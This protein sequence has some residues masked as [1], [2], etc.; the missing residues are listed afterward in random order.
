V[1]TSRPHS[2]EAENVSEKSN[3][4]EPARGAADVEFLF[5]EGDGLV[6]IIIGLNLLH[7]AMDPAPEERREVVILDS[8]G[9]E[10]EW[11]S[12]FDDTFMINDVTRH[13]EGKRFWVGVNNI[14]WFNRTYNNG[15]VTYP[16][17][18][19]WR[20]TK[21]KGGAPSSAARRHVM[22]AGAYFDGVAEAILKAGSWYRDGVPMPEVQRPDLDS[23]AKLV[24]LQRRDALRLINAQRHAVR[25]ARVQAIAAADLN[26]EDYLRCICAGDEGQDVNALV[27]TTRR[28]VANLDAARAMP[29]PHEMSE[30]DR[31]RI[32]Q[33]ASLAL[34]HKGHPIGADISRRRPHAGNQS[35]AGIQV[36]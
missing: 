28:L 26:I 9:R 19:S 16:A 13:P 31:V 30:G 17:S 34:T 2:P 8:D 7:Q 32:E 36:E 23:S 11:A 14:A 21:A 12:L 29:N 33:A 22:D 18:R 1:L 27:R 15:L 10:G 35:R 4:R 25:Q 5:V 20:R 6:L 3:T 24:Y